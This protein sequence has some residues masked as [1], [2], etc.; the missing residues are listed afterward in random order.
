MEFVPPTFG[1]F[2]IDKKYSIDDY[3]I[4]KGKCFLHAWLSVEKNDLYGYTNIET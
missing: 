2:F 1:Y 3:G 4:W